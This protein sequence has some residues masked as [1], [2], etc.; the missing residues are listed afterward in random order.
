MAGF[1]GRA[2]VDLAA[3]LDDIRDGR[4]AGGGDP[5]AAGGLHL[6]GGRFHFAASGVC[7]AVGA[8]GDWRPGVAVKAIGGA[9]FPLLS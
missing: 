8:V 6:R 1:E 3:A 5:D 2:A 4:Y 9:L 7:G